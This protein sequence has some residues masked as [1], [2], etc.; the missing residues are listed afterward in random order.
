VLSHRGF[1]VYAS[2]T[3]S[4]GEVGSLLPVEAGDE[5]AVSHQRDRGPVHERSTRESSPIGA[6]GE[7][8]R[9]DR[10]A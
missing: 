2:T 10:R 1:A 7:D 5:R 3:Q 9:V 6:M 4:E 8:E